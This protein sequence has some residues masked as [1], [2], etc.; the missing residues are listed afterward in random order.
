VVHTDGERGFSPWLF[1]DVL[2]RE[3]RRDVK[4]GTAVHRLLSDWEVAWQATRTADPRQSF[5]SSVEALA[6]MRR[7]ADASLAHEGF[8]SWRL[9]ERVSG[10]G[11]PPVGSPAR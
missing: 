8:V 5:R 3:L 11:V 4:P 1:R 9:F 2:P 6:Q 7:D 10:E